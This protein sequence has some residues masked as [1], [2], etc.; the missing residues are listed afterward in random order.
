MRNNEILKRGFLKAGSTAGIWLICIAI[1][2]VALAQGPRDVLRKGDLP[3]S[4]TGG[5]V[6]PLL[7]LQI[8]GVLLLWGT[9][10]TV[11]FFV[12]FPKRLERTDDKRPRPREAYGSAWA[13][14]LAAWS[15]T[16]LLVFWKELVLERIFGV[17]HN[18]MPGVV[19][20]WSL[21]IALLLVAL[22][23]YLWVSSHFRATPP[24]TAQ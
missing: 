14:V 18:T 17:D 20:H 21:K 19:N 7:L 12:W 23:S 6:T 2:S 16:L 9:A 4:S 13:W 8:V 11:A 22:V 1:S 24:G 3:D 15:L 10:F 5:A